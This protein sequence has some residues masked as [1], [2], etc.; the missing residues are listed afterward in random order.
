MGDVKSGVVCGG[1]NTDFQNPTE[2]CT[3]THTQPSQHIVLNV[4]KNKLHNHTIHITHLYAIF[5]MIRGI[6]GCGRGCCDEE[7]KYHH[8][9]VFHVVFT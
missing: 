6:D 9:L 5:E 8:L 4:I 7:I 3:K 1:R 2:N